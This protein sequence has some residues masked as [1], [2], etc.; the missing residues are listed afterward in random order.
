MFI[1]LLIIFG[2][3]LIILISVDSIRFGITPNPSSPKVAK[4]LLDNLPR[5]N[6]EKVVDLGSGIGTMVRKLAKKYPQAQVIGFEGS[7]P[8]FI[9]S[10]LIPSPVNASYQ[11]TNFLNLSF[12]NIDLAYVYLCPRGME[13]LYKKLIADHPKNLIIISNTF[14]LPNTEAEKVIRSND[15]YKTPIYFY[16]F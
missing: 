1:S 14:A 11:L 8:P 2:S 4:T 3:A 16:K 6:I 13:Q 5:E 15:L 7:L 10:L 9:L 12:K